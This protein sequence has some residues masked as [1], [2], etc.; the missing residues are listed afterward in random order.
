MTLIIALIML[1]ALVLIA[2]SPLTSVN[3][4]AVAM[5]AGTLG[6][7]LYVCFGS[8][9]VMAQHPADYLDFISGICIPI[10]L[11]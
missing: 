10:Y 7:V 11:R 6:W 5:F 9:F 3:K 2:F 8:D 1:L 4:A